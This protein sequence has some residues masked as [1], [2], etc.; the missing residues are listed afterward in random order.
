MLQRHR[1]WAFP[2]VSAEFGHPGFDRLRRLRELSGTRP[3]F[4]WRGG[5]QHPI[6]L[7]VGPVKADEGYKSRFGP[8]RGHGIYVH[9]DLSLSEWGRVTNTGTLCLREGLIAESWYT[10]Y[11]DGIWIFV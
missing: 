4:A 5:L 1:D 10:G 6:T 2:I 8:R 9:V 3:A 7:P 11:T